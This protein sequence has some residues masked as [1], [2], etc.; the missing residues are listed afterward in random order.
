MEVMQGFYFSSLNLKFR[1]VD[2][3]GLL[4][5]YILLFFYIFVDSIASLCGKH[6]RQIS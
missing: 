5:N 6:K 2:E 4:H 1:K 3:C